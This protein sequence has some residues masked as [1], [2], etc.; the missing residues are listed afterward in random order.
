MQACKLYIRHRKHSPLPVISGE[1]SSGLKDLRDRGL[2]AFMML[3]NDLGTSFNQDVLTTLSLV[4]ALI[5]P[6]LLYASDFWGC[7]KLPRS[8]PIGNL[9]MMICK[10]ILGVQKQTTNIGVLLELG[11]IP[12]HLHATKFAIKNWERIKR[13]Q[14]NMVLLAS[15][16][17][18]LDENLPW[19]INIKSTLE[20]NGM[21]NFY[22]NDYTSKPPFIYKKLFQRLSDSF[23]QNSF[24]NIKTE[25]SK[26]RTYG[27]FKKDIG[28]EKYLSEVKNISV[29]TQVTKFRLSNHRLMIEVGRH[30]GT[31]KEERFCPFCPHKIENELHFLFEC[32][33]Y[34]YQRDYLLVPV[35]NSIPGLRYLSEELKLQFLLSNMDYT[36]C[37]YIANCLDLRTFL[38]SKPKRVS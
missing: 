20:K 31:P 5:K 14:A 38:E 6:I 21:L 9:H 23:H 17:D 2:K 32:P 8:N 3:K 7:L 22:V 1:I 36:V 29:R 25:S 27:I 30:K 35:M 11:R 12:M 18:S 33:L 15:Y 19:T 16:R 34:N 10:Q 26:L 24:E 13:G 4:D 28:F 37:K